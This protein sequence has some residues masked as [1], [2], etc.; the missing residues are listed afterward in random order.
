[1]HTTAAMVIGGV[2]ARAEVLAHA[3]VPGWGGGGGE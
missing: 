2:G 3:H 1:M